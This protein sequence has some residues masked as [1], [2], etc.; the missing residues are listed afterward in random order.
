MTRLSCDRCGASAEGDGSV[1]I[2]ILDGQ[3]PFQ[4]ARVDLC[5]VCAKELG[6]WLRPVPP[7]AAPTGTDAESDLIDDDGPE[8]DAEALGRG[9]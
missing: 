5:P 2:R 9:G 1:T 7:P 6:L 4:F 8:T 3:L